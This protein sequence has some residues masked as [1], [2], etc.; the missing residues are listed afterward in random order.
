[1]QWLDSVPAAVERYRQR[2]HDDVDCLQNCF[3]KRSD[4]IFRR[5]LYFKELPEWPE[6]LP[7]VLVLLDL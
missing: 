2:H 5:G 1:M 4:K 7:V 3:I 6:Q